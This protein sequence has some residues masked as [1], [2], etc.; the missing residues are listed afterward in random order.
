MRVSLD[1]RDFAKYPF[2]KESQQFMLQNHESVDTFLRSGPGKV[3]LKYAVERIRR[4]LSPAGHTGEVEDPSLP[5][6][7]L[8]IRL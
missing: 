1:T 2:L 6:D 8:G 5:S 3:A 7:N 4:A